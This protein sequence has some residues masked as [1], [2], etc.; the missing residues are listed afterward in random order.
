MIYEIITAE[1]R[2]TARTFGHCAANTRICANRIGDRAH[3]VDS[4]VTFSAN[5][6]AV[7]TRYLL[8]CLT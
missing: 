6:T 3:H 5:S 4:A 1:D 8:F 7:Y 2:N